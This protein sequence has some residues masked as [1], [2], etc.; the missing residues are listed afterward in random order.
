MESQQPL[1]SLNPE[2]IRLAIL[3]SSDFHH[4]EC[5]YDTTDPHY[6]TAQLPEDKRQQLI[7]ILHDIQRSTD[8]TIDFAMLEFFEC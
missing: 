3:G 7:A 6:P 5:A 8:K 2:E 4:P 1:L